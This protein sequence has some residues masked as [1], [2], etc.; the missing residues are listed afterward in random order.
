MRRFVGVG[1]EEGCWAW[2][3]GPAHG[4]RPKRE[5]A[6]VVAAESSAG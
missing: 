3:A 4:A 2:W 6:R 5:E 1:R